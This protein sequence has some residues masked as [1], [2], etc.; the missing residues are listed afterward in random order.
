MEEIARQNYA[1]ATSL[2]VPNV[3]T[4]IILFEATLKFR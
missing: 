4:A 1:K 2:L 3:L